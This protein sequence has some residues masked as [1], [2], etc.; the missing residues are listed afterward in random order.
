MG[1][2]RAKERAFST[3]RRGIYKPMGKSENLTYLSQHDEKKKVTTAENQTSFWHGAPGNRE[4][5]Q[6]L[7][8]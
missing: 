2:E 1:G 7:Q 8:D 6:D 3:N 4:K 5:Q